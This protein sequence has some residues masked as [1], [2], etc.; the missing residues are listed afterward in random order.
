MISRNR[1]IE[2]ELV[3]Q[4]TLL[5]VLMPHHRPSPTKKYRQKTES[6][7]AKAF[8]SLLQQNRHEAADPECPRV[9]RYQ[10]KSRFCVDRG[11]SPR[12]MQSWTGPGII[13]EFSP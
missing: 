5:V 9:G 3:E 11:K 4:R 13:D 1:F 12:M 7:F 2:T 10:G 6:L 8:K